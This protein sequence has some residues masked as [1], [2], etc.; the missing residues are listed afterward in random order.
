MFNCA[1]SGFQSIN[2][3]IRRH[4]VSSQHLPGFYGL[5]GHGCNFFMCEVGYAT[6]CSIRF[7]KVAAICIDLNPVGTIADLLTHRLSCFVCSIHFLNSFGH[8]QLPAVFA[9]ANAIM[10][11]CVDSACRHI[12]ARPG[13][14]SVVDGFF[15]IYIGIHSTFRFHI[16]NSGEA[17]HERNLTGNTSAQGAVRNAFFQ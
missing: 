14:H 11:I 2:N 12:H 16:A 13:N 6:K 3:S 7:F 5:I 15:Q 17:I 1:G 4:R 8:A 9:I 10:T